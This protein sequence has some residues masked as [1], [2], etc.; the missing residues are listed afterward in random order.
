MTVNSTHPTQSPTERNVRLGFFIA[1]FVIGLVGNLL[2]IVIITKRA[3]KTVND[4]FIMNLAVSDLMLIFFLPLHIY[5][6]FDTIRVTAFFCHFIRPLMTAS[7]FVSVYTLTSM[8]IHRCHV[9]LHPFKQEMRHK[10]AVLWIIAL[11]IMSFANVLPL[12][13]VTTPDPPFECLENWPSLNHRRAYTAALFVLQYIL[14]LVIIAIA[15]I[16]I[17]LDLNRSCSRSFRTA[18]ASKSLKN[19]ARR[20]ENFK[21]TKTLAIIVM[22]FAVCMLPSQVGWMLLDFGDTKQKA[23]AIKVIFKFSLV[24]TVFHSCLNPLVYGSITKQFRRGYVKYLSYLCYCC[25]SSILREIKILRISESS[26]Q[27]GPDDFKRAH[28]GLLGNA[29]LEAICSPKSKQIRDEL[30][31]SYETFDVVTVL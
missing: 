27:K 30:S 24:L 1:T 29:G 10:S 23:I 21:V 15:Y 13:I 9:I 28:N 5:G 20:R 17:G 6:M 26:S 3:K 25:R 12:M 22:I 7:F 31:S 16:R 14:P 4:F 18:R 11:W 19:Q 8:A 2:V